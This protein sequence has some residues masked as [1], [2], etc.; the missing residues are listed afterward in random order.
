[1]KNAQKLLTISIAAYNVEKYIRK[2]LD[3]IVNADRQNYIE[4][5][6]ID[7][8]GTDGTL[9]IA[10][11]YE[12]KYPDTFRTVHKENGGYGSTINYGIKH[13]V[14]KYFKQLDGDDWF[15]SEHLGKFVDGLRGSDSDVI[16]TPYYRCMEG[17]GVEKV[18][19]VGGYESGVDYEIKKLRLEKTIGMW[20]IAYRTRMLKS[21]G[22]RLPAHCLY[23][24]QL[25]SAIP[26]F[27]HAKTLRFADCPIYCYRIGREGQSVSRESRIKHVGDKIRV[28]DI[29]Y[30]FYEEQKANGNEGI[31]N[32]LRLAAWYSRGIPKVC[33]LAPI[34]SETV[35][36]IAAYD[37]MLRKRHPD[38][39]DMAGNRKMGPIANTLFDLREIDFG[40]GSVELLKK[41]FPE[42]GIETWY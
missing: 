15:D 30:D 18:D 29:L 8:G 20:T 28:N 26:L 41:R 31:D 40:E 39:Y 7:D 17:G 25:Y 34:N 3:S 33:L 23:T 9:E 4:V 27:A 10:R 36:N 32:I 16:V 13:A 1:M 21:S 38:I 11:E 35:R 2:G 24:D 19:V 5:Y 14:G 42:G 22:L 12:R 6:V 37:Q